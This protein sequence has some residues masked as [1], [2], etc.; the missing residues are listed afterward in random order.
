MMNLKFYLL[1]LL[2]FICLSSHIYAQEAELT[3]Q[4]RSSQAEPLKGVSIFKEELQSYSHIRNASFFLI[5]AEEERR[6]GSAS[7]AL[8][9]LKKNFMCYS[10]LQK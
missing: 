4:V 10:R 5:L 6:A 9:I 2:M 8:S 7:R 3:G 1:T